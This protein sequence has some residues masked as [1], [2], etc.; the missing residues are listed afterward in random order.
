VET[1]AVLRVAT[2]NAINVFLNID[3]TPSEPLGF[4]TGS[5]SGS[6][7]RVIPDPY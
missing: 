7:F 2:T 6:A 4:W 5:S 1:S 3:K